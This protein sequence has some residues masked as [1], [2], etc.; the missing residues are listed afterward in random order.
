MSRPINWTTSAGEC[1]ECGEPGTLWLVPDGERGESFIAAD[2]CEEHAAHD[3]ELP[4]E[5]A[6]AVL[7]E[8]A[9][10]VLLE[11][12]EHTEEVS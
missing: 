2:L 6:A 12:G 3:P 9:C 11:A 5:P 1:R 8:E 7:L 10:E 4:W